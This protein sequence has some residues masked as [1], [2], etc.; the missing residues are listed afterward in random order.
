MQT[1]AARSLKHVVIYH[2]SRCRTRHVTS[3]AGATVE[4]RA[5]RLRD[6]RIRGLAVGDRLRMRVDRIRDDWHDGIGGYHRVKLLWR[7]ARVVEDAAAAATTTAR[8]SS[9]VESQ[10]W[11]RLRLDILLLLV[12]LRVVWIFG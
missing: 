4:D 11:M 6:G 7:G 8:S 12:L 2:G 3:G 9:R 5:C 1:L 10:R